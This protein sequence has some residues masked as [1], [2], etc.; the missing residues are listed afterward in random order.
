MNFPLIPE[1]Q[2]DILHANPSNKIT[3]EPFTLPTSTNSTRILVPLKSPFF[4]K[5]LKLYNGNM[6]PLTKKDYR[7]FK[8]MGG[9][10]ELTAKSVSC[11][12]EVTNKDITS[13]FIDYDVVG[14][15][16][17]FDADM[18]RMIAEV[19]ADGGVVNYAG[20]TNKPA[21]FKP[22]LHGHS[23]LY[24]I[25]AFKDMV[26]LADLLLG[27]V[28]VVTR[29]VVEVK[30]SQQ[31]DLFNHYLK[32]YKEQL[33]TSLYYHKNAYDGHGLTKNQVDLGLVDNFPT[34]TGIQALNK[35]SDAHLTPSGLKAIIDNFGTNIGTLF[36][37][38]RL[39]ISQFGNTNFIPPSIDGSFEGLGGLSETAGI[40]QEADGS[41]VFLENRYDGRISGLYYSV[42]QDMY[43]PDRKKTYTAY[44]YTHQLIEKDD[45]RVNRI[46]AGSGADVILMADTDKNYFYV[47]LTNGSLN[48]AKHVLSRI[49]V[50]ALMSKL[51][52]GLKASN[53]IQ[54]MQVMLMGDWIYISFSHSYLNRSL[55]TNATPGERRFRYYYRVAKADVEAQVPVTAVAQRLSYVDPDGVTRNNAEYFRLY[56]PVGTFPNFTKCYFPITQTTGTVIYGNCYAQHCLTAP[57]PNKPG[58]HIMKIIGAFLGS[59]ASSSVSSQFQ[60]QI[61]ITYEFDPETGQ[62]TLLHQTPQ[63]QLN[64]ANLFVDWLNPPANWRTL[65]YMVYAWDQ[66]GMDVLPDGSI[67]ASMGDYMSF[68]RG[69]YLLKPRETRTRYDTLAKQWQTSL[70]VLDIEERKYEDITS[71][72]VS[73]VKPKSFLLGNGGDFYVADSGIA[74]A[75]NKLYYRQSAG[76]LAARADIQNKLVNNIRARPL[77]NKVWEVRG[78]P[79]I[80]GATVTVPSS[81]LAGYGMDVGDFRF[82]VG[83]Q[84]KYLN[85]PDQSAEWTQPA[86]M[87]S[88]KVIS[89]H[90]TR[91]NAQGKL[92]IVPTAAIT[93]PSAIVDLLKREVAVPSA[94]ASAPDV[95]VVICDPSGPLTDKFGWLPVLVWVSF[96]RVGTTERHDTMLSITPVYSGVVNR[97]VTSYTVLDKIHQLTP[98][99]AVRLTASKWDVTISGDKNYPA[100]GS[101][102]V[103][104]YLN[105][106]TLTGFFD[107]GISADGQGDR[108]QMYSEFRYNNRNTSKRWATSSTP[109]TNTFMDIGNAG[110]NAHRAVTPDNGVSV[111]IMHNESAGGA[112]TIFK[113]SS[114]NALLGSA[115]PEVGWIIFFQQEIDATFN[116]V[117]YTLP[118][119]NLDLRTVDPAPGNKTFYI[120]AS[121]VDGVAQYETTLEKRLE[122]GL[123][124][125][126]GR[127][128]T[129][130]AS[131]LTIERFNV[132]TVNGKRISEIKR[133]N[134]IPASSG[135]ANAEGQLPWIRNDELLP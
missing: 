133:G 114:Y 54:W 31:L 134:S 132:F 90:T 18:L 6:E 11:M 19:M 61:E 51:P 12:I 57:I 64:F 112:A 74:Q 107:S 125:W 116:G 5:S 100:H 96:G 66:Q 50:S 81:Q 39:P 82:C 55:T 94:I 85:L 86:D 65:P 98:T 111:M 122:N 92:E 52:T 42:I 48:P 70:G 45:A 27:L 9:L 62:M 17:L 7:I 73:G 78:E 43:S 124:V 126:V 120:Y 89:A 83:T 93:Y 99:G 37:A 72:L 69:Y 4:A 63:R 3:G 119:G 53:Y 79:K 130:P 106:N 129:G 44:R 71:P 131:I 38:N 16:T 110:G 101:P 67:M 24:D 21:H 60:T 49:D 47:G 113:G 2:N 123:R 118:S 115:Y 91:V 104:Y 23:L 26:E 8:I 32:L 127:V 34:V 77:S 68:P 58:K 25:V 22:K 35:R 121:L 80:G 128:V 75:P 108:L 84:R 117:P 97:T 36:P 76:G 46:A 33:L 29:T 15:F 102:R 56:T 41:V 13:G 103:G 88:I 10:T 28:K 59:Y 105:G 109:Y 40:C 87:N 30:I 20:I 14:E 135:L 95:V 1:Y